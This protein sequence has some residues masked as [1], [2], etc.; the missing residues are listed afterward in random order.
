[1]NF[2]KTIKT[3]LIIGLLMIT[4]SVYS[5]TNS[6]IQ[7]I[8]FGT[9]LFD[10]VAGPFQG[11]SLWVE[12]REGQ[13]LVYL[14]TGL[15]SGPDIDAKDEFGIR[16]DWNFSRLGYTRFLFQKENFLKGFYLGAHAGIYQRTVTNTNSPFDE[17]RSE[18]LAAIGPTLGYQFSL[19][20]HW[21]IQLWT[22]P[23]FLLGSNDYT[24]LID[25]Q[26][27]T[28]EKANFFWGNGIN[29]LYRFGLK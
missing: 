12:Y 18:F 24:F 8:S 29:I 27:H 1:M 25:E 6:K 28:V 17:A 5:Q 10:Y 20:Q 3:S 4:F 2:T 21:G 13:N 19:G 9:D 23:R 7:E 26:N 22:N 16:E 15:F 11:Y 14:A